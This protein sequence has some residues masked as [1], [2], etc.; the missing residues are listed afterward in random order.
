[1]NQRPKYKKRKYKTLIRK[2]ESFVPLDL[3]MISYVQY[4]STGNERKNR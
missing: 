3:A 4:Q 1:M 2:H